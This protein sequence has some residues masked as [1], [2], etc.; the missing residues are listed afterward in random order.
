VSAR[1]SASSGEDLARGPTNCRWQ[2]SRTPG[3]DVR[4]PARGPAPPPAAATPAPAWQ[5]TRHRL[6][7]GVSAPTRRLLVLRR[8]LQLGHQCAAR[9]LAAASAA[10]AENRR[11]RKPR[12]AQEPAH[13]ALRGDETAAAAR[14]DRASA[15]RSAW[16]CRCV[17]SPRRLRHCLR[18]RLSGV[19]AGLSAA[20]VDRDRRTAAATGT[21]ASP[22]GPPP[23]AGRCSRARADQRSASPSCS[24]ARC[25]AVAGNRCA[26]NPCC[27]SKSKER[28]G[29]P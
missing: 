5:S 27:C 2:Q 1:S 14:A 3:H 25:A 28:S 6:A 22:A 7:F 11:P 21:S 20:R 9:V 19:R 17:G 29:P 12:V 8:R 10:A 13:G 18:D 23:P 16:G 15:S 26:I 24:L 4:F